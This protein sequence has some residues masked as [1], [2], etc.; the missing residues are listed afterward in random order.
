MKHNLL[1]ITVLF[2]LHSLLAT[3]ICYAQEA[4]P[5]PHLN[6]MGTSIEGNI[7]DF[8]A[9]LRPKYK[10]QKKVGDENYYIYKG[11]FMGHE[12]YLKAEYTR[13]SR[14]VYRVTVTP[15]NIDQGALLDSMTVHYGT[16]EPT[17]SGYGWSV[18]GGIIMMHTPQGYDPIVMYIDRQGA[19]TLKEER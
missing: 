7:T 6:F 13:K 14:T 12:M 16:P 2:I 3:G 17:Q 15:K 11:P 10:L 4:E 9:A 18:D 1:R 5:Q 8:T 19:L